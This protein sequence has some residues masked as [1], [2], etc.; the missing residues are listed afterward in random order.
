MFQPP[1]SLV[2]LT[3]WERRN[4]VL[5]TLLNHKDRFG[6]FRQKQVEASTF[7][8]RVVAPPP[9]PRFRVPSCKMITEKTIM[10]EIYVGRN[11]VD[12]AKL[13]TWCKGQ[14]K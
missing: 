7:W 4:K 11:K 10:D 2:S 9:G 12:P 1:P 3:P 6:M 8:L 5:H 14:T 13:E